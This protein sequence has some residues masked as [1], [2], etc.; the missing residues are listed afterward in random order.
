MKICFDYEIFWKQKFSGIASRYFFNLI[1]ILSQNNN[2]DLKVFAN[3]YLNQK[4]KLLSPNIIKGVNLNY[5]IPY[6][7]KILET[8]NSKICNYQIQRFKP[9]I[10]HKTYYSNKINKNKS[11]IILTVFDLWHEKFTNFKYMPKSYS[12]K[13]SDHILCPSKKT[14]NDLIDIYK[15]D[16]N[17]ITVTYFGI[18]KFDELSIKNT[19]FENKK[20]F[21]L[22]VGARG[23]YKNFMNFINAYSLSKKLKKD[24]TVFC[25]GGGNFTEEEKAF[26]RNNKID[27]LVFKSNIDN[28]ETLLNLYKKAKCLVYPSSHEGL[29]LP[30]LEAMSLGCPVITSNHEGIIEGVGDAAETFDPNN[31]DE[32]KFKIEKILYSDESINE[33]INK[34]KIQSKKFSWNK[35]V[36]ETWDVYNQN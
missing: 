12:I 15:V 23:R 24:F 36:K 9:N 10:I 18:E 8:I 26:F 4:L 30:P 29:G 27:N 3:L 2:I 5:R 7:G 17:K 32:I 11:K 31:V 19:F 1:K 21:I 20:P 33:L 22:F 14:K 6:T 28:D 35:C 25:F 13:I 34:G 16:K